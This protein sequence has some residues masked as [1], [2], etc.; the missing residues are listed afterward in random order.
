MWTSLYF[1]KK[2]SNKA[3]NTEPFPSSAY[4]RSAVASG[5]ETGCAYVCEPS[6]P[7]R[8]ALS[9]VIS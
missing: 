8:K 5:R 6:P 7:P 1:L 2:D 9:F 4:H 3:L